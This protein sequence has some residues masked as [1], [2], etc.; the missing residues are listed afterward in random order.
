MIICR[1]MGLEERGRAYCVGG[2]LLGRF[3]HP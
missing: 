3:R 2:V 1:G